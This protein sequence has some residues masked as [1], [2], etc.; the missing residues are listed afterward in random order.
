MNEQLD[1]YGGSIKMGPPAVPAVVFH[2]HPA[3]R[4][5]RLESLRQCAHCIMNARRWHEDPATIPQWETAADIITLK[6][7]FLVTQIDGSTLF[8]CA[9]HAEEHKKRGEPS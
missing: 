9:Q 6:A 3:Q 2:Q 5:I 7:I 1:I 4:N 8:L